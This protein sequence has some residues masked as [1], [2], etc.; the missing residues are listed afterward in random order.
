M[1]PKLSL[2]FLI[3]IMISS[4]FS[5]TKLGNSINPNKDK[6]DASL[7]PLSSSSYCYYCGI[8]DS[9]PPVDYNGD[10]I[11]RP[12]ILG[13]QHVNPYLLPNVQKAYNNLGLSYI[14]ATVTN[15]Y[16]RFLPNSP[17]Q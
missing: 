5:C 1:A 17:Q 9:M 6:A 4:T 11:E 8:I 14:T 7:M 12:T 13:M 15:L 16:V 2:S 3:F 10:S